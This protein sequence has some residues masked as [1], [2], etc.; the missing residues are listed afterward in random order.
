MKKVNK[1][2][3][4]K[5]YIGVYNYILKNKDRSYY[6]LFKDQNN[7]TV[8]IKLGRK[9][10]GINEYFCYQQRL[11][12][13]SQIKREKTTKQI[14]ILEL[15]ED[16]LKN[17]N[18]SSR[19]EMNYR[20]TIKNIIDLTQIIYLEKFT[21]EKI[22]DLKMKLKKQE[23]APKTINTYIEFLRLLFNYASSKGNFKKENPCNKIE[24]EKINNVRNR[25]LNQ[26]EIKLLRNEL[27]DN[28]ELLLFVELSLSTGGRLNTILNIKK[29]D[30]DL[31]NQ[32]IMLENLKRNNSYYGF[33]GKN[34]KPLLVRKYKEMQDPNE[35]F[36]KIS[37]STLQKKLKK[38][39]DKLFNANLDKKD[40]KNR[41]VI[42]SLRHSFA[43]NLA[44]LG[45]PIFTI[46]TLL[47]H[48]DIKQ[49]IRY[50][51]LSKENGL[52]A[53]LKL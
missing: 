14:N 20:S 52:N 31:K 34:L 47:D 2:I 48:K 39:F 11:K 12:I 51:K 17:K 5:K 4:S 53:V 38:I 36:I 37:R 9:S 44:I 41:V 49:T 16:Y 35:N 28:F 24:L 30:I 33:I 27:K 40:S 42:H 6:I 3:K 29:K 10:E 7:K 32:T 26:N 23:K 25:F 50:S 15:L 22:H 43:S 45:V 18:L 46:M 19:T 13:L 21:F 8:K 1:L